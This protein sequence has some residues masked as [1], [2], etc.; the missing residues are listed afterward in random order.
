M[1]RKLIFFAISIFV[2]L[3]M[4]ACSSNVSVEERSASTDSLEDSQEVNTSAKTLRVRE[5]T[6]A[7]DISI[8]VDETFRPIVESEIST[9]MAT[10]KDANI[11]A[12]YLPGE[13]AVERMLNEDSI[14]LVITSREL[15]KAEKQYLIEQT[16]TD[17]TTRIAT[18][19]VALITHKDNPVKSLFYQE[20]VDILTGKTTSWDGLQEDSGLDKIQITF[21]H[22]HSSTVKYL[23][24]SVLKE[25]SLV[26]ENVFAAKNNAEVIDYVS[27]TPNT[28]GII[29][30]AW[31]SDQDDQN[32]QAF[33]DKVNVM[34]I[35]PEAPCSFS[36]DYKAFQPYQAF[37]KE[38][39]YPLSR[40]MY[41]IVRESIYGLGK[42][43]VAFLAS[44]PGQRIIHKSGLV[45]DQGIT[46]LVKFPSR[47][48]QSK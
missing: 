6:T 47:S 36:G 21:D 2:M 31:I 19:A 26:T 40:G 25:K 15:T 33:L 14:R 18:D 37:I 27:R 13:E 48:E 34:K 32:V 7:G 1:G 41:A 4:Q 28:L 46:R 11:R 23:Q 43:F 24:D 35:V 5:T 3:I 30:V 42:G 29:G 38:E 12:I 44:D 8:A 9:F 16:T 22:A 10:Y 17:K 39:C 20:L 45:P